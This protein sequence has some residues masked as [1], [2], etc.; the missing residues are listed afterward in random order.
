MRPLIVGSD[1][2]GNGSPWPVV[3]QCSNWSCASQHDHALR[4][5]SLFGMSGS[6][7]GPETGLHSAPD[8]PFLRAQADERQDS[9]GAHICG[10]EVRYFCMQSR[11][12]TLV[13]VSGQ[14]L[15]AASGQIPMAVSKPR[16]N[17]TQRARYISGARSPIADCGILA[18]KKA[19]AGF[20][21]KASYAIQPSSF[22][23]QPAFQILVMWLILPSSN[24]IT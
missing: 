10:S 5:R 16:L 18:R 9:Q 7:I 19:M 15:M 6:P 1:A 12:V 4:Q 22:M 20:T 24:S 13:A 23:A 11:C 21:L 3:A 8:R 2:G 17:R 14:L